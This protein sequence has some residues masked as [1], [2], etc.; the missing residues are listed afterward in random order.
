MFDGDLST[1]DTSS[2]TSFHTMFLRASSFTGTGL[3]NWNVGSVEDLFG[4]FWYA[5]SFNED[6]SQWDVS[7]AT[8][9]IYV[10]NS[11]SGFGGHDLCYWGSKLDLSL[12]GISNTFG[13]FTDSGCSD[14]GHPDLSASPRGPFCQTCSPPTASPTLAPSIEPSATPTGI[15]TKAPTK[16]PTDAPTSVPLPTRYVQKSQASAEPITRWRLL[17]FLICTTFVLNSQDTNQS[18]Y[19]IPNNRSKCWPKRSSFG[20]TNK[21][22]DPRTNGGTNVWSFYLSG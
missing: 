1:W 16:K 19:A 21:I 7:S 14:T 17:P 10:A 8:Q 9:L 13:A 20:I 6:I 5:S 2:A 22:S 15:P 11:A 12:A 18:A 3:Q 4:T